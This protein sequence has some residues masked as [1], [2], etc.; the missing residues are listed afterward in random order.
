MGAWGDQQRAC[1][2]DLAA[3]GRPGWL[4]LAAMGAP[5]RP[6]RAGSTRVQRF[7]SKMVLCGAYYS[8]TRG[9]LVFY[10][11]LKHAYILF[12]VV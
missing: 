6:E 1:W 10:I 11:T 3:L 9:T 4:D 8:K 5:G 12:H 2:L 7:R